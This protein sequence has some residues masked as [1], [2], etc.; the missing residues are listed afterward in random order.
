VR[1]GATVLLV[2]SLGWAARGAFRGASPPPAAGAGADAPVSAADRRQQEIL[3]LA[4]DQPADPE[5]GRVYGDIN[6]RHFDGR[7][8]EMPVIWEPRLAEVGRLAD[9]A[10]TLDG[11]FGHIGDKAV[12]LLHPRLARDSAALRRALS[13]EMVHAYLYTTGDRSNDHGPAFQATLRRLSDEGAFPGIAAGDDE[14]ETLRRWIADHS[15]RLDADRA[16]HRR[17]RDA[18]ATEAIALEEDLADLDA[19]H[20]IGAVVDDAAVAA[21]TKRRDDYNRRV[22]ALRA[23]SERVDADVAALNEQVDRYNQMMSYP[24]GLG[25]PQPNPSRR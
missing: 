17:E 5:L 23:R 11:M 24:D 3:A 6:S 13:H 16:Q 1:I 18:L 2:A 10:F 15:D 22:E 25:E 12:I 19:L 21:W 8:P 7:L 9:Q 4:I 20:K 14:R